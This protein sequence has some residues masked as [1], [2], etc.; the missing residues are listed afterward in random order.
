MQ[1]LIVPILNL[2]FDEVTKIPNGYLVP[3]FT[4]IIDLHF[5]NF[6]K[7]EALKVMN[8]MSYSN[9]T[10]FLHSEYNTII[11]FVE[12]NIK[13][14]NKL[15]SNERMDY[16]E[17]LCAKYEYTLDYLRIENCI[18]GEFEKLPGYFGRD[19]KGQYGIIVD[20][21]TME[22]V[23]LPGKV[24]VHTNGIGL[25]PDDIECDNDI[26]YDQRQDEIALNLLANI[27]RVNE[28]YYIE[29]FDLAFIY[30]FS[31]IE[32]LISNNYVKFQ[33]AKKIFISHIATSEKEY[34]ELSDW[35]RDLSMQDRTD[36]VHKGKSLYDKYEKNEILCIIRQMIRYILLFIENVYEL[37]ILTFDDLKA[38][39]S[40]MRIE[41]GMNE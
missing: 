32:S 13:E 28:V 16:L 20:L 39:A 18:Y 10:V 9:E 2:E 33:D 29:N 25:Y 27:R 37:E 11:V 4:S 21:D 26:F 3:K 34:H 31:I 40:K 35:Y 38:N 1:Y 22:D 14:L 41:I 5:S 36:L 17:K 15:S 7:Q 23:I 8:I 19:S 6:E 30:T 12:E 24:K